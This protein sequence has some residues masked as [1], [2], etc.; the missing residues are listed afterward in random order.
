MGGGE[1][2]DSGRAIPFNNKIVANTNKKNPIVYITKIPLIRF[3]ESMNIYFS[4]FA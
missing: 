2:G 4:G 1:R 3:K